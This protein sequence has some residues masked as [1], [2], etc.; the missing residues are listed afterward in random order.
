MKS[1]SEYNTF[2]QL[3]DDSRLALINKCDFGWGNGEARAHVV[4]LYNGSRISGNNAPCIAFSDE[5]YEYSK[6]EK[7]IEYFNLIFSTIKYNASRMIDQGLNY[8]LTMD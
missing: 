6:S 1:L 7:G 5:V 4:R 2:R 3:R 8:Y